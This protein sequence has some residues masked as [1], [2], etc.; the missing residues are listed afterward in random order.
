[1]IVTYYTDTDSVLLG[2]SLPPEE[3]SNTELGQ[4]KLEYKI[5][6]GVFL[7]PKSYCLVP[8]SGNEVLVHKGATK[9]HVFIDWYLAQYQDRNLKKTLVVTNPFRADKKSL[10]I[11]KH[12]G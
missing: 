4:F 10:T 6:E 12:E 9:P 5:Q 8:E 11:R 1:M 2:G 3:I 7:A